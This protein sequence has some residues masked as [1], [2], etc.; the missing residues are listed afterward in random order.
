MWAALGMTGVGRLELGRGVDL[1]LAELGGAHEGLG[2]LPVEQ[3][4]QRSPQG[5]SVGSAGHPSGHRQGPTPLRRP[6]LGLPPGAS[7]DGPTMS[8]GL[9]GASPG[10]GIEKFTK[11]RG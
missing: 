1:D 5:Q 8:P 10:E 6:L 7:H 4:I 11:G 3:L 9:G 2:G